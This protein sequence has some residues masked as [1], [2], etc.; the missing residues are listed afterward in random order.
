[1]TEKDVIKI[2]MIFETGYDA[3]NN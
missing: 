3:M 1:M 2:Y